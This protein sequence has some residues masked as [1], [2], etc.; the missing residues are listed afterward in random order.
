MIF[1]INC[2]DTFK[3][4][5]LNLMSLLL[6]GLSFELQ[7]GTNILVTGDSGCGKSSLLRVLDG[8]WPH[9]T[10]CPITSLIMLF[11]LQLCMAPLKYLIHST[12]QS[13]LNVPRTKTEFGRCVFSSTA[14]QIWNQIPLAIITSPSLNCFKRHLETHYFT[15]P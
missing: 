12:G 2:V 5:V 1:V 9:S 7:C 8:L 4:M 15:I 14:P 10:G 13:L 3:Q 11:C 6:V